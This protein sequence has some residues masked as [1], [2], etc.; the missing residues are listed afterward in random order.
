MTDTGQRLRRSRQPM[1]FERAKN[2]ATYLATVRY[3]KA[4]RS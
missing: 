3:G 2:D 4:G 1:S